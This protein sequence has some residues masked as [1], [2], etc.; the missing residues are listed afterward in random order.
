MFFYIS[1]QK[2][3]GNLWRFSTSTSQVFLGILRPREKSVF[4]SGEV[5]Q[6]WK[7]CLNFTDMLLIDTLNI[8]STTRPTNI[9]PSSYF[10]FSDKQLLTRRCPRG[11]PL[12]PHG[13]LLHLLA[14]L[15]NCCL[16]F[17]HSQLLF[18]NRIF[19]LQFILERI[20]S[21]TGLGIVHRICL[22]KGEHACH[23]AT[24][25]TNLP[26]YIIFCT[27]RT[28]NYVLLFEMFNSYRHLN[29]SLLQYTIS[30]LC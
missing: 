30:C 24:N 20:N 1:L 18:F 3:F 15:P 29:I 13:L 6:I 10:Y 28:F 12:A 21:N 22:G 5:T 19:G 17:Q 9:Y 26:C 4:I 2:I 8:N 27:L 25:F 23:L 16:I 11:R 14:L 7:Q